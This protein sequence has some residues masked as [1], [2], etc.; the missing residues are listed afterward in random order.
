MRELAPLIGDYTKDGVLFRA[1]ASTRYAVSE[2]GKVM[3]RTKRVLKPSRSEYLQVLYKPV[4]GVWCAFYVHRLIAE[5]WLGPAPSED[6]EV[7]HKDGD[8]LNN[9]KEN[10]EWVT[11]QQNTLHAVAAGMIHNLPQKGQRGF[12]CASCRVPRCPRGRSAS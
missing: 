3:G 7:N 8:K 5:V 11:H 12:Q 2:C 10:L 4:G 1:H 6:H 9:H